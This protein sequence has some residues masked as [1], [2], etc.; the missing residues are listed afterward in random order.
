[1]ALDQQMHKIRNLDT[2]YFSFHF[3]NFLQLSGF[4]Y[5]NFVDIYKPVTASSW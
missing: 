1:M 4:P 3:C 2:N 5:F